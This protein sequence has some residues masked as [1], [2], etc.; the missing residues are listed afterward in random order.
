MF[1]FFAFKISAF[2]KQTQLNALTLHSMASPSSSKPVTKKDLILHS[3]NEQ[4]YIEVCSHH[5]LS[6]VR[7][8]ILD[9]LDPEQLPHEQFSFR[10]NN[11][12]I[13]EKQELKKLA[14]HFIENDFKVELVAKRGS[15]RA[16]PEDNL[17]REIKR[18]RSDESGIV[19]PNEGKHAE[20]NRQD[21][22]EKTVDKTE[23]EN[24]SMIPIDLDDKFADRKD[25]AEE[26]GY[27]SF[28]E[29]T[30]DAEAQNKD[31]DAEEIEASLG[32]EHVAA[33][34]QSNNGH[35]D[36]SKNG[37]NHMEID[38]VDKCSGGTN[39]AKFTTNDVAKEPKTRGEEV[40]KSDEVVELVMDQNPH[41][42][43]D[44]AK[45]K[46]N[47]VLA[48]LKKILHDN[49]DFC[50]DDRRNELLEDI[51]EIAESS[52]PRTVFGVLGNTGV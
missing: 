12:R 23:R 28:S 19:T 16:A 37:A 47:Q 38:D 49:P 18:S 4:S 7:Q 34:T 25:G 43:A 48:E 17:E 8:L 20:E 42:E 13:S 15:K 24:N 31:E 44:E 40:E 36:S 39:F 33:A 14:F 41:K 50:T 30:A 52:T 9:E 6:D 26:D 22:S 45:G 5:T 1:C 27:L 32:V 29:F 2:K 46:S 51:K 11:I 3:N 35:V 21:D 10:I